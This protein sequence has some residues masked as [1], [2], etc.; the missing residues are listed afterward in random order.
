MAIEF[1]DI[2]G[3]GRE[4][5]APLPASAAPLT[6]NLNRTIDDSKIKAG[7]SGART[8][9]DD[10]IKA[11][12]ANNPRALSKL[13]LEQYARSVAS[14]SKALD[15][16][17]SYEEAYVRALQSP[18]IMAER[19]EM[20]QQAVTTANHQAIAQGQ[21]DLDRATDV[22]T[23]Q[24]VV[25]GVHAANADREKIASNPFG[26]EIIEAIAEKFPDASD[27][28]VLQYAA[29]TALAN[30]LSRIVS[31]LGVSDYVIGVG[32][33]LVVP[34]IQSW[35]IGNLVGD[36]V[37]DAWGSRDKI[38]NAIQTFR[39]LPPERQFNIWESLKKQVIG[40]MGNVQGTQFLYKFLNPQTEEST[41]EYSDLWVALDAVDAVASIGGAAASLTVGLAT[42]IS[43]ANKV[44]RLSAMGSEATA[45][46][47]V[48]KALTE[49]GDLAKDAIGLTKLEAAMDS[50]PLQVGEAMD[51]GVYTGASYVTQRELLAA[52]KETRDIL[53]AI[54]RETPIADPFSG[55]TGEVASKIKEVEA[56][57][58]DMY[59]DLH[60]TDIQTVRTGPSTFK[61]TAKVYDRNSNGGLLRD[62]KGKFRKATEEDNTP[63]ERVVEKNWEM[64]LDDN[65]EYK[66]VL[67]GFMSK[68]F[69]SPKFNLRGAS[70][71]TEDLYKALAVESQTADLGNKLADQLL[72]I[73]KI[74]HSSKGKRKG[75][76]IQ[77]VEEFLLKGDEFQNTSG[78]EIGKIFKYQELRDAVL[79]E[80][81]IKYYYAMRQFSDSLHMFH[82]DMIRNKM[83]LEGVKNIKVPQAVDGVL[84]HF[85][86]YGKVYDS[87]AAARGFVTQGSKEGN[88]L[89]VLDTGT[90]ESRIVSADEW[91]EIYGD[92]KRLV[93][94]DSHVVDDANEAKFTAAIVDEGQ[95]GE[96]PPLVVKSKPGYYP[97]FYP[98]GV[99]ATTLVRK[100]TV[101]GIAGRTVERKTMNLYDNEFEM[102]GD[103]D[104][105]VEKAKGMGYDVGE[106]KQ[107]T[108]V[109]STPEETSTTAE[110]AL[111][112]GGRMYTSGR[113][114]QPVPFGSKAARAERLDPLDSIQ[115]Q[116]GSIAVHY[117]RHAQRV[118]MADRLE[119]FALKNDIL[120][121]NLREPVKDTGEASR[122]LEYMRENYVQ[123]ASFKTA[124]ETWSAR[125]M[126]ALYETMV[127]KNGF[128][129]DKLPARMAW[130]MQGAE[131]IQRMRTAAFHLFL[132]LFNPVQ[133]WRQAQGG[134]VAAAVLPTT[135]Y[136][137]TARIMP[138]LH[139]A[140]DIK[141]ADEI[142]VAMGRAVKGSKE[143]GQA[144]VDAYKRTGFDNSI[145]ASNA[146]AKQIQAEFADPRHVMRN[147][148][149][150]GTIFYTLGERFNRR[151]SWVVAME[152]FMER[153]KLKSY[154]DLTDPQWQ[155]IM[156]DANT[157]MLSMHASNKARWQNGVMS[158]PTQFMQ[159]QSK[160]IEEMLNFDNTFTGWD[161]TRILATQ[162]A[163]YGAAGVPFVGK[164]VAGLLG[165]M[166]GMDEIEA[167]ENSAL[168]GGLVSVMFH[169]MGIDVAAS[170]YSS[171]LGGLDR[172]YDEIMGQATPVEL[173]L[174][175]AGGAFGRGLG[176]MYEGLS[177]MYYMSGQGLTAPLP[178]VAT[179]AESI[180]GFASSYNNYEQAV[181]IKNYDNYLSDAYG[182]KIDKTNWLTRI[183]VGMG[184]NSQAKVD[185]WDAKKMER[186]RASMNREGAKLLTKAQFDVMAA[187]TEAETQASGAYMKGILMGYWETDEG[188]RRALMDL[189]KAM[190]S[191][192]TKLDKQKK[193][194]Y[195]H[196]R[197]K[198]V[199]DLVPE[200]EK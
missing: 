25:T 76:K 130:S 62:S 137:N 63:S 122:F 47:A 176:N 20:A 138:A 8:V 157:F 149:K 23:A 116:L 78:E 38:I 140:G 64:T 134:L 173:L 104:S 100:G 27:Q 53:E 198:M 189:K 4:F 171:V 34:A 103:T 143:D 5:K 85:E 93:R 145:M 95:I 126:R 16:N 15:N 161:K 142:Y 1:E 61:T 141:H 87:P 175:A 146:D 96:I 59:D 136:L 77:E 68:V 106:G 129:R 115:R 144:I 150:K 118:A 17:M 152:R 183:A 165:D 156:N 45:G 109:H 90:G 124:E 101:N 102:L 191:P 131:P 105:I 180:A 178:Y 167:R 99:Y 199:S 2:V 119:K 13:P 57:V 91:E 12:Y 37:L 132:G 196:M 72:R 81:Q 70:L 79:E 107:W 135:R 174:G 154:S 133:L 128:N 148:L 26:P 177:K 84:S 22:A 44:R 200:L 9:P 73:S 192:E 71:P 194:M 117:P 113:G 69:N 162:V 127:G 97:R 158:L 80:D 181:L 41:S 67:K 168:Q 32:K 7:Y 14:M 82:N 29:D 83:L 186:A 50:S 139:V 169:S 58:G 46:K 147:G 190:M 10:S 125:R 182:N 172:L 123:W 52:T 19:H 75:K 98:K 151:I 43:R 39:A 193:E 54:R 3:T 160:F 166:L 55:A 92:G 49:E 18:D 108:V 51:S 35:N 31:E 48:A 121:F 187:D 65:G 159:V 120:N 66:G 185:Y 164:D 155:T 111:A 94:L 74:V 112:T 42:T 24:A 195:L 21:E 184:F 86:G 36:S 114:S 60:V 179:A 88:T 33:Q 170:E 28:Q 11:A 6:P 188:R 30:D 40:E 163:A 89:T 110:E 56:G 153:N 197:E